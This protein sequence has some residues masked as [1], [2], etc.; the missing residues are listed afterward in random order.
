MERTAISDLYI[1]GIRI[2]REIPQGTL[3]D[4]TAS[5]AI[6]REQDE[7]ILSSV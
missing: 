6:L 1:R 7:L 4:H 3:F 5:G 2:S